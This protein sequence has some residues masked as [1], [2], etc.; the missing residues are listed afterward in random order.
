MQQNIS[1]NANAIAALQNTV[2]DENSGLVAT[3]NSAL[4]KANAAAVKTEVDSSL[5]GLDAR[6]DAI[7]GGEALTGAK[8]LATR[9]SEAE[10][11]IT[12]LQNEPKSAT[13]V[14]SV[15][16]FEALEANEANS[17]KDYLVG[18][19]SN[20]LYKYYHIIETSDNVYTKV[21]ISGGSS[22][23]GNTSGMDLTA[24]AY[25]DLQ[26]H[27]ENTDYYVAREDGVH[28][29]RWIPG[30]NNVLEEIEISNFINTNNIKTYNAT[31]STTGEGDE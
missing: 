30:S 17:H 3:A 10:S 8:T 26:E 22:G 6:L 9:V 28:H 2:G 25:D 12:T 20:N 29:Y 18:P 16:N 21:L 24:V 15:E 11:A 14:I 4:A 19:D 31:T 1:D 13:E 5:S 7:D 23:S 27:S